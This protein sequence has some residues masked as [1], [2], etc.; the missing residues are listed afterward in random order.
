MRKA[1]VYLIYSMLLFSAVAYCAFNHAMPIPYEVMGVMDNVD[2]KMV[3]IEVYNIN[4][5]VMSRFVV[6]REKM[7]DPKYLKE[8]VV[9]Q[10]PDEDGDKDE[11][12]T[13]DPAD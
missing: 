2:P 4:T 5:K 13:E 6:P 11:P 10:T 7:N 8:F 1:I 9:D 3:T 12:K